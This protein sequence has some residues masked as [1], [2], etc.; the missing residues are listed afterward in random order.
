[1][2]N[3]NPS[4]AIPPAPQM[5][6][7]KQEW[8]KHT[9]VLAIVILTVIASVAIGVYFILNKPQDLGPLVTKHQGE[10]KCP[11]KYIQMTD[12]VTFKTGPAPARWAMRVESP[13]PNSEFQ[14]G[15]K[16]KL[17]I[18]SDTD[19]SCIELNGPKPLIYSQETQKSPYEFMVTLP[20]IDKPTIFVYGA[21]GNEKQSGYTVISESL[22]I[23]VKP[24]II[25]TSST[26]PTSQNSPNPVNQVQWDGGTKIPDQH[27]FTDNCDPK[28]TSSDSSYCQGVTF[29]YYDISTAV[30]GLKAGSKLILFDC[31]CV[32]GVGETDKLLRFLQ[33]GNKY[34][35]Q[36]KYSFPLKDLL[37][38]FPEIKQGTFTVNNNFD[39]PALNAAK[40]ITDSKSGALIKLISDPAQVGDFFNSTGTPIFISN[41]GQQVFA[42]TGSQNEDFNVSAADGVNLIYEL[43]DPFIKNQSGGFTSILDIKWNDGQNHNNNFQFDPAGNNDGG[44]DTCQEGPDYVKAVNST[45]ISQNDLTVVGT[46]ASGQS[47][48]GFKNLNNPILK[49]AQAQIQIL[50]NKA[51]SNPVDIVIFW[52]DPFGRLI[53]FVSSDMLD[54]CGGKPVIYLYPTEPTNVSVHVSPTG[55][56]SKSEPTYHS[57]WNVFAQPDGALTSNGQQYPYLFWEGGLGKYQIPDAGFVVSKEKVKELLDNKL[58]FIGLNPKEISD[59][60]EF[61]LQRMQS[62]PYY[63]VTFT[64]NTDM[65]KYAPL[66]INPKPD[67]VIRVLMDYKPL[68]NN[69]TVKLLQ[70]QHT[71]RKGFTVVEWGGALK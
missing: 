42:Q 18:T 33:E 67:T 50:G 27:L 8:Y 68:I 9:G 7:P 35:L 28:A 12:D 30:T 60:E 61:W 32:G 38:E 49:A 22:N 53:R 5:T 34:T 71:E 51:H 47:I 37:D 39:I 64:T 20:T 11:Q 31:G 54:V 23:S 46:N 15:D 3:N 10:T 21:S 2:E 58:S 45:T 56:I 4:G 66:N 65:E 16:I 40:Q 57:G 52:K 29:A 1:M 19:L 26:T 24:T 13:K 70:L 17:V 25:S 6:Q 36:Q 63:F 14:S 48:Y 44:F 55:G 62:A 41:S 69:A 59:F 43:S